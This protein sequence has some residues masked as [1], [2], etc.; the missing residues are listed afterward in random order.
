MFS[1][2][3]LKQYDLETKPV[4]TTKDPSTRPIIVSILMHQMSNHCLGP[5]LWDRYLCFKED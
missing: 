3:Y 4:L 5:G 1:F 2:Q